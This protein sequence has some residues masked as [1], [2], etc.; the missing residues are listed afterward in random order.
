[1]KKVLPSLGSGGC[2]GPVSWAGGRE[3]LMSSSSGEVVTKYVQQQIDREEQRRQRLENRAAIVISGS[4]AATAALF[5]ALTYAYTRNKA[6]LAGGSRWYMYAGL[7]GFAAAVILGLVALNPR[8]Q[9]VSDPEALEHYL[10]KD[11]FVKPASYSE[12]QIATT[13][14]GEL[15]SL[16]KIND[17][18]AG[19]LYASQIVQMAAL[20]CIGIAVALLYQ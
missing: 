14:L 4:G 1:M 3:L 13:S 11:E 16:T 17:F 7:I 15:R 20:I 12:R 6:V 19:L 10:Q 2:D 18:I 5:A 9:E 8:R